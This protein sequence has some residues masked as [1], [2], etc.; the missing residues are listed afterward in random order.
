MMLLYAIEDESAAQDINIFRFGP[1]RVG[2]N[3]LGP[4]PNTAL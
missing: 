2:L 4:Q 1:E 3:L